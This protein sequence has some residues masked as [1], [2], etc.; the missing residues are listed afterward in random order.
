MAGDEPLR[1]LSQAPG[2]ALAETWDGSQ[3]G[4]PLGSG[5]RGPAESSPTSPQLGRYRLLR[6]LGQ[7]GV[8][9]VHAAYDDVLDR[10][11]ALKML[12]TDCSSAAVVGRFIRE[13]KA[14]ARVS[15][16]NIV[17]IYDV[18]TSAGRVFLAM[19]YVRGRTLRQQLAEVEPE[20]TYSRIVELFVAAGRGLAEV[21]R[22]GLVH[23]DFKPDN[24]MV[25]EDGRVLLLD[26]GLVGD[27]GTE[28]APDPD[29][30]RMASLDLTATGSVLGTPAY[31]APEQHRG[32]RADARSD[33]FSFCASL[34]EAL[35]G[36]RPFAAASYETLRA[37]SLAGAVRPPAHAQVPAW[38][39]AVVLRGLRVDPER[40]WQTM[41]QLLAAL[42]ADPAV[43]RRVRLRRAGLALAIAA[44]TLVA[45]LAAL[46]LRRTWTRERIEDLAAE[47]LAAVAG[48]ADPERAAA[49]FQAFLDDPAHQGTQALV[50]AWQQRGDRRHAA[51][52]REGAL[53]DYAR[54]Y[55]D[56]TAPADA[57]AALRR[58]AEL[59][60]EGWDT[61][62]L[63]RVVQALPDAP[64]DP[65]DHA[66]HFHAALRRRDL[67]AAVELL[68]EAAPARL[69]AV[70]PLLQH[71]ARARAIDTSASGAVALPPGGPWRAAVIDAGGSGVVL[72]DEA[73]QPGP[74]WQAEARVYLANGAAPWGVTFRQGSAALLD[75]RAPQEPLAR[76]PAA[77]ELLPRGIVDADGDGGP[78]LYFEYRWPLRGFHAVEADGAAPREAHPASA[79]NGS[80]LEDLIAGDLDGDGVQEIVAAFGPP[81]AFDLRVFHADDDGQ[82]QLVGRRQ[83]GWVQ[84][85]GL[86]RR[87]DGEL[88]LVA[89]RD[90]LGVN[91]DVFPEPPHIGEAPGV[92]LLRWDGAA[93]VTASHMPPP[94]GLA[95]ELR[96]GVL[97]AADLD[98]DAREELAL[99]IRGGGLIH[100]LLIHQGDDGELLPLVLGHGAPL[101]AVRAGDGPG[102]ALLLAD[103]HHALWGL[104]VGDVALP[105]APTPAPA[106]APPPAGLD[107]EL[108]RDRWTR[109]DELA[110]GGLPASAAEVLRAAAPLVADEA[111]R[112]RFTDRAAALHAVAGQAEEALA[113]DRGS[114]DDPELAPAAWLRRAELLTELGRHR[115]A[116]EAARR[117]EAHPRRSPAQAAAASD[118]VGRL[119]PLLD[120]R[121]SVELRFAGGALDPAW[122]L[123]RPAAL[124]LDP[125]SGGLQ[126]DALGAQTRLATLPVRWD[127]GP[128]ELELELEVTHAEYHT[129]LRV[130]LHDADGQP[131]LGVGVNARGDRRYRDH[132]THCLPVA[133]ERRELTSRQVATAATRR[134]VIVRAT[135]F[136]DRDATLCAAEDDGLR[137]LAEHR[138]TARPA[139]GR[140]TL[141]LGHEGDVFAPNRIVAEIRR[142]SLHGARIDAPTADDG[143]LDGPSEDDEPAADRLDAPSED[144]EPA[145]RA[146]RALVGGEP[147]AALAALGDRAGAS[148]RHALLALLAHD[149]LQDVAGMTR[150]AALALPG[151]DDA[152]ALHLLRTRP[153][154]APTLRAAVGPRELELLA[155]TWPVL[156]RHH[157]DDP[158]VQQ[159]MLAA[160]AGVEALAAPDAAARQAL[161][162]L[163]H[164]R[165]M[166]Y[167]ELGATTLARRDFEAALAALGD[168]PGDA[169]GPQQADAD[170]PERA[171]THLALALLLAE[172][173]PAAALIHAGQAVASDPAPELVRDRLRREPAFASRMSEDPAWQSLLGER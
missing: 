81:R 102:R 161:R 34:Y 31:M 78:E 94:E 43:R 72:L 154:L 129:D 74:R 80:D 166:I 5:P 147:L 54:A 122:R 143:Q 88:V 145:A 58:I 111:V 4:G 138:A 32:A 144:D 33:V 83:F 108:L 168:E 56:A 86:L 153:G 139:A 115:E 15:H 90:G 104:G 26:F 16:L 82:L 68:G 73:L 66:L 60:L 148:P 173:D 27:D 125:L 14:L 98:G 149:A 132:G 3:D 36:E 89:V 65:Q 24:V 69:A 109:A 76:F 37:A 151:L 49:A 30:R 67:P 137:A 118:V 141:V 7:G 112:R 113:L 100:T 61:A 39:R 99:P 170:G 51:G 169:S 114:L 79:R 44:V 55:A 8:G 91:A 41:S 140:Y 42:A 38:L 103:D 23:R 96:D 130:A 157:V 156:A 106:S 167:R 77:A 93:L 146:A 126:V 117:L 29:D 150:M 85:L 17:Q 133:R 53:A 165:A 35:Y 142:I 134:R 70:R 128:L 95:L 2:Q 120:A 135:Y 48:E 64:G 158:M 1:T 107:D 127:G 123:E 47:H 105:P 119:A 62:A 57:H 6:V 22:A 171:E 25:G 152:D 20:A 136:P 50:R 46:H 159:A 87:P 92:H 124:R 110:A 63:T 75:L 9:V 97:I 10:V 71:L 45:T 164:G 172:V 160:L 13:A 101:A 155:A 52:E 116:L 84:S 11:V 40:R 163:L 131:L 59:H 162:A 21:H 28:A 19:E 18:S 121:E 12:R